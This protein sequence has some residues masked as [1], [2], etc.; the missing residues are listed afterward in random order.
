MAS[1]S[2]PPVHAIHLDVLKTGE[3]GLSSGAGHNAAEAAAVCFEENSHSASVKLQ[4]DGKHKGNFIVKWE[5]V[6]LGVRNSHNDLQDATKDG[7]VGMA[8]ACA[9]YLFAKKILKQSRK[10]SGFDYYLADQDAFLFQDSIGYE[11][12]G[13]LRNDDSE[14]TRRTKQKVDQVRRGNAG[15]SAHVFVME[16]SQPKARTAVYDHP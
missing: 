12:S 4:I 6:T 14:I 5:P 9:P 13:I 3:T 8:A 1:P 11:I 2:G 16:F 15:L 7:A 10:K